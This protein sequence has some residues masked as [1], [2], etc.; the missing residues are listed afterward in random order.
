MAVRP[1]LRLLRSLAVSVVVVATVSVVVVATVPVA[2][3]PSGQRRPASAG[4]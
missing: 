2:T 3:A 1:I 4:R